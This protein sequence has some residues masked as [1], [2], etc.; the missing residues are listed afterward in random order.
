MAEVLTD[1]NNTLRKAEN[2]FSEPYSEIN[3]KKLKSTQISSTSKI[4]NLLAQNSIARPKE[5][6]STLSIL[7]DGICIKY[8]FV[9]SWSP[10]I[11]K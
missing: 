4:N 9:I 5:V 7:D 1:I 11:M 8:P 3:S 2:E 6:L 10:T